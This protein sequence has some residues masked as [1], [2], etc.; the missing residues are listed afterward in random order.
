MSA[1]RPIAR[2]TALV[3]TAALFGGCH[4]APP[5]ELVAGAYRAVLTTPGGDLPFGISVA[6]P[7]GKPPQVFL[8]NGAGAV[9]VTEFTHDGATLVLR[10]PGYANRLELIAD[11]TGYRGEAVIVRGAD[12]QIHIPLKVV[13]DER[14]RF[15]TSA[16]AKP[17]RI[18]G[19]WAIT[20]KSADGRERPAVGE[21]KQLGSRLFGTIL[22]PTGDHR[23]LEGDVTET[24]VLLSSFD[25]G[26]PYL[27][28]AKINADGTL[29]GRWWTGS[30]AVED[31]T[32]RADEAAQLPEAPTA[33]PPGTG[34]SFSFPGLDGKAVSLAD[35]RFRGKV[36]VVAV[37]G[38]WC[39]NC[40]DEAAFLVGLYKD[41]KGDGLEVVSLQFEPLADRAAATEV[42]RRF[43]AAY[44]IQWPVLLAGPADLVAA[45]KALPALGVLRAFPTT[46]LIGRDGTV[47]RIETG[48]SGPATGLH[49]EEFRRNFTDA[50]RALLAEKP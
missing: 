40:H 43:V 17:A 41:L 39:P 8:L 34:L 42:N 49:Y 28:R 35:A 47:R 24:E 3:A 19:R 5:T 33:V 32:A 6:T 20:F 22:D 7:E 18:G 21:L 27:Y 26:L 31:F 38:T 11:Q 46:V 1:L 36:V 2:L 25:G 37:G 10:M 50:V 44:G 4:R 13:R 14:H 16:P 9:Q 30:W 45:S 15:T 29:T 12:Q 23:Y 48:F